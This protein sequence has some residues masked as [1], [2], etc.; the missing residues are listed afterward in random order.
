MLNVTIS[1][2]RSIAKGINA[3]GYID[4]YRCLKNN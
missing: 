2:F 4:G 1:K 3:D